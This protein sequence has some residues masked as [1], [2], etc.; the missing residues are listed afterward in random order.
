MELQVAALFTGGTSNTMEK[1]AFNIEHIE[2]IW[3]LWIQLISA[4]LGLFLR[5]GGNI[6]ELYSEY[7]PK[8]C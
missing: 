6:H 8:V 7:P 4:V 5:K 3:K 1:V 2:N